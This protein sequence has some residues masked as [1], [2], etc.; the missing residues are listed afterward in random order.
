MTPS[1]EFTVMII[2]MAH[3]LPYGNVIR[4]GAAGYESVSVLCEGP[5]KHM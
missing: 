2:L 4:K 3:F 1:L 5:E